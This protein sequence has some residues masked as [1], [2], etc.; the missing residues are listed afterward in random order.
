MYVCVCP[1]SR[2]MTTVLTLFDSLQDRGLPVYMSFQRLPSGLT[3]LGSCAVSTDAR[4]ILCLPLACPFMIV[5]TTCILSSSDAFILR[6]TVSAARHVFKRL[7]IGTTIAYLTF[8]PVIRK[9]SGAQR[10]RGPPQEDRSRRKREH[11]MICNPVI[12][13]FS[14][15]FHGHRISRD[16]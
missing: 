6:D 4:K 13:F 3:P 10:V 5:R 1:D 11:H 9:A 12:I 15:F 16:G 14:S 7:S 2:E 8:L